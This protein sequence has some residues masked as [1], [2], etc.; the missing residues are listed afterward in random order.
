MSCQKY[1]NQSAHHNHHLTELNT[2]DRS[3]TS[4]D[5]TTHLVMYPPC[6]PPMSP[7]TTRGPSVFTAPSSSFFHVFA[8]SEP[9]SKFFALFQ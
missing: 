1:H 2:L 5:V 7:T 3:T 6:A 9:F 4:A 8:Y